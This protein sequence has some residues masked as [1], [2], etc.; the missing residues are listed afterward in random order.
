MIR[1]QRR[2]GSTSCTSV[3]TR[4]LP[5][6][7]KPAPV[8]DNQPHPNSATTPKTHSDPQAF[9][10][11]QGQPWTF[12]SQIWALSLLCKNRRLPKTSS[13]HNILNPEHSL[14]RVTLSLE[15]T[16]SQHTAQ[17][18][19]VSGSKGLGVGTWGRRKLAWSLRPAY[20]L[21]TP[22]VMFDPP[23][24]NPHAPCHRLSPKSPISL[25]KGLR[26]KP[27]AIRN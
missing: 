23:G 22:T 1:Q 8:I 13:H 12:R 17:S 10:T 21:P 3:D 18:R 25:G 9:T 16:S 24:R 7:G 4:H 19:K 14:H 6:L 27:M 20:P 26:A 5:R 2:V 11:T 15:K